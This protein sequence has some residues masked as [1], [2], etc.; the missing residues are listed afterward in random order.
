MAEP[1]ISLASPVADSASNE[2]VAAEFRMAVTLLPAVIRTI[3]T[4]T[5][6]YMADEVCKNIG[7][8]LGALEVIAEVKDLGKNILNAA[9]GM[10]AE[11]ELLKGGVKKGEEL[12]PKTEEEFER[13][14]QARVQRV[15]RMMVENVELALERQRD[16]LNRESRERRMT[17][18]TSLLMGTVLTF[19]LFFVL[20]SVYV[21]PINAAAA[22]TGAAAGTVA[23]A[24]AALEEAGRH[25]A[26][27][28]QQ[29]GPVQGVLYARQQVRHMVDLL[30]WAVI[31]APLAFVAREAIPAA[32]G[33]EAIPMPILPPNP[34]G[35]LAVGALAGAETAEQ[36]TQYVSEMVFGVM[37]YFFGR[38][39]PWWC[40]PGLV[41]SS[42][43]IFAFLSHLA[44]TRARAAQSRS[45]SLGT[46]ATTALNSLSQ[47]QADA[48]RRRMEVAQTRLIMAQADVEEE[49][50]DFIRTRALPPGIADAPPL[51]RRGRI[52]IA[53]PEEVAE[54]PIPNVAIPLPPPPAAAA[55][56]AAV[57]APAPAAAAAAPP[58]AAAEAAPAGLP[59][60][61]VGPRQR[62]AEGG[63]DAT[64]IKKLIDELEGGKKRKRRGSIKK[65]K[66]KR[67]RT[68]RR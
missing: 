12:V 48:G 16:A 52:M 27:A 26:F 68:Y 28:V 45:L 47:L 23:A 36:V 49:R 33:A 8:A 5:P 53:E 21:V 67:N 29:S 37:R 60:A 34:Q 35:V 13:E 15:Q 43:I 18:A 17:V 11:P 66:T 20:Y 41:I 4:N 57:P 51:P 30:D 6:E 1:L 46:E 61:N 40:G 32:P 10:G 14:M 31:Q 55:P 42:I 38:S 62:P 19:V 44:M 54:P 58:P 24:T 39:F 7:S 25:A 9:Q 56:A 59:S 64:E 50:A 63:S 22:A 65:N 3:L 2:Q